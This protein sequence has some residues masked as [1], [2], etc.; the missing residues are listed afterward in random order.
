M[1]HCQ[2]SAVATTPIRPSNAA[3]PGRPDADVADLVPDQQ[4]QGR[5]SLDHIG[6][7]YRNRTRVSAVKVVSRLAMQ[8]VRHDGERLRERAGRSTGG[9]KVFFSKL[10]KLV[11]N[12]PG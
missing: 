4:V 3:I 12:G 1:A 6:A 9:L 11:G 2:Q 5:R 8:P 10:A 7:P